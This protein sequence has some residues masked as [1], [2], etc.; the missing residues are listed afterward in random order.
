MSPCVQVEA[1]LRTLGIPFVL[2]QGEPGAALPEFVRRHEVAAL[3]SDFSPL[4]ISRGWKEQLV[5]V[6]SP[7][8]SSV[9]PAASAAPA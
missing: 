5:Q 1:E 6:R 7:G 3:V 9:A 4:R 2:L 8:S